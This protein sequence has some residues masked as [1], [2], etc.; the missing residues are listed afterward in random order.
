MQSI[1]A[2]GRGE[3]RGR[4]MTMVS[5]AGARELLQWRCSCPGD[6]EPET[7]HEDQGLRRLARALVMR[8]VASLGWR[9]WR[10]CSG[11]GAAECSADR[12][13]HQQDCLTE[14]SEHAEDLGFH[15]SRRRPQKLRRLKR[16]KM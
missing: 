8:L 13:Q 12:Y 11:Q 9:C 2:S 14:E 3:K 7:E 1:S 6:Q 16:G 15:L 5:G 4:C 10:G